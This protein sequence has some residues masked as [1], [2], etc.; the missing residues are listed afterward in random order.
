MELAAEADGG[1]FGRVGVGRAGIPRAHFDAHAGAGAMGARRG[2]QSKGV[3]VDTFGQ[4]FLA[5]V[6]FDE[7]AHAD[8]DV[9]AAVRGGGWEAAKGVRVRG[10]PW[11]RMF[12]S[13]RR[14]WRR[15][16]CGQRDVDG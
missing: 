7:W 13:F 1:L 6:F 5:V 4:H 14:R 16:A 15:R 2:G 9:H 11:G 3:R 10:G 12:G 8:Y